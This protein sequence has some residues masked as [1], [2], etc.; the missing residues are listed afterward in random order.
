MESEVQEAGRQKMVELDPH[1]FS[2]IF[3]LSPLCEPMYLYLL[4]VS[5]PPS[6]LLQTWV[7]QCTGQNVD[8]FH[9]FS[10]NLVD[11]DFLLFFESWFSITRK[12]KKKNR[13]LAELDFIVYMSVSLPLEPWSGKG[14]CKTEE[15][16]RQEILDDNVGSDHLA[17]RCYF[18]SL[19]KL[20]V[21]KYQARGLAYSETSVIICLVSKWKEIR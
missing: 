17:L 8:T 9:F 4:S 15:I 6:L 7:P 18:L 3:L 1:L 16:I 5:I 21:Y 13:P 2:V 11:K 20:W 10:S 12:G 14:G 19:G